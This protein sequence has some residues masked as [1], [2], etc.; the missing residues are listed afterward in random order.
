MK[1]AKSRN[2]KNSRSSSG[3][4]GTVPGWRAASSATIRGEAEP[5]WWTCSSALGRP[6]T[7]SV[8][9]PA[10]VDAVHQPFCPISDHDA[11]VRRTPRR[12]EPSWRVT[13]SF[14]RRLGGVDDPLLEGVSSMSARTAA[15]SAPASTATSISLVVGSWPVVLR[16]L[17]LVEQVVERL[18]VLGA[19]R[20]PDTAK[21]LAAGRSTRELGEERDGPVLDEDLAVGDRGLRGPRCDRPRTPADRAQEVLVDHDLVVGVGVA[22]VTPYS[23]APAPGRRA[24][25]G[26]SRRRR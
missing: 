14:D 5:T 2:S 11:A 20:R 13:P 8:E 19:G 10:H 26:G 18:G 25:P 4:L 1:C 3:S 15:S 7:K 12:R 16:R 9:Q 21:A 23:S 24:R 6:P 17:V 22:D